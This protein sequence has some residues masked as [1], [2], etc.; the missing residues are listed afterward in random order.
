MYF[1]VSGICV[2]LSKLQFTVITQLKCYGN[3]SVNHSRLRD[4]IRDRYFTSDSKSTKTVK[5]ETVELMLE[6]LH[7]GAGLLSLT[8]VQCQEYR[9][10]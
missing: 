5:R 7:A 2:T 10:T 3:M 6:K 1:E 9:C 8:A 4:C